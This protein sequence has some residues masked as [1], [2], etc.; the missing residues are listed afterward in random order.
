MCGLDSSRPVV[1]CCNSHVVATLQ[2]F[3]VDTPGG[4]FDFVGNRTECALLIMLRN[5]GIDYKTERERLHSSLF[6]VSLPS[7]LLHCY[8]VHNKVVTRCSSGTTLK[9][10][11]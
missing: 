9:F 8:T 3:L 5:W 1:L 6:Q 2:A 7:R 4:G 10:H 11:N